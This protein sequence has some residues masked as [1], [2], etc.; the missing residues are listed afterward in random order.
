MNHRYRNR[1]ADN[2]QKKVRNSKAKKDVMEIKTQ[3]SHSYAY[4]VPSPRLRRFFSRLHRHLRSTYKTLGECNGLECA[5]KEYDRGKRD[6]KFKKEIR[7]LEFMAADLWYISVYHCISYDHCALTLC[8]CLKG[9]KR[10]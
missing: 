2:K 4:K 10:T 6:D 1:K 9:R 5:T 7:T 8:K 3:Q